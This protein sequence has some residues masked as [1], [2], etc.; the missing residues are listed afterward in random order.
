MT[1]AIVLALDAEIEALT[2]ELQSHPAWAKLEA[3]RSL[4]ALYVTE[5]VQ[6]TVTMPRAEE[7]EDEATME[8]RRARTAM[9]ARIMNVV[10]GFFGDLDGPFRTGQLYAAVSNAGL[11]IPGKDPRN[12]LSAMLSN[13]NAFVSTPNGWVRAGS[14]LDPKV[15]GA[16][17]APTSEAPKS[18]DATPVNRAPQGDLSYAGGG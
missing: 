13:S 15:A 3:A 8:T 18:G 1:T 5:K 12:N 10:E 7:E 9:K 2:K 16:S 11:N 6:V 17:D 14:K 4:R